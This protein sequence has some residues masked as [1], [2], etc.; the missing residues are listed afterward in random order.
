MKHTILLTIA[1]VLSIFVFSQISY[2]SSVTID[3]YSGVWDDGGTKR[4]IP[5]C[6]VSFDI[7]F[8]NTSGLKIG[9][10]ANGFRVWTMGGSSFTPLIGDTINPAFVNGFDLG[11]ALVH[12]SADGIGADTVGFGAASLGI[13]GLTIGYDDVVYRLTTGGVQDGEPLCIDRN[14][15]IKMGLIILPPFRYLEMGVRSY[16]YFPILVWTRMFSSY[17][18]SVYNSLYNSIYYKF[19]RYSY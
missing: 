9:G 11:F 12:Y 7:R 16:K 1:V 17:T 5:N 3:S 19:Y 2:A 4:I 13:A 14:L 6:E 18:P 15:S 10:V 8:T